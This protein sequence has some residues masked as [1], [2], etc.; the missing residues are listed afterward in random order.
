MKAE[1]TQDQDS[2][3]N[4]YDLMMADYSPQPAILVADRGNESDKI[5]EDTESHNAVRS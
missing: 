3:Y 1:I 5:R 2:D 4:G